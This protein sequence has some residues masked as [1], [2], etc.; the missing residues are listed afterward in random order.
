MSVLVEEALL[1]I[2]LDLVAH[3]RPLGGGDAGALELDGD[4]L[5]KDDERIVAAVAERVEFSREDDAAA[6]CS[7]CVLVRR[8]NRR[9]L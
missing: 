9:R 2:Y 7:R 4:G 8:L 1:L 6:L 3:C 5:T